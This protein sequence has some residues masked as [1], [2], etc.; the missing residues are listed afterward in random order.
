MGDEARNILIID[1][2]PD[3]RRLLEQ[4]LA[5]EGYNILTASTGAEAEQIYL[6]NPPDLVITDIIMPDR[7]G[8]ETIRE[9]R[10][11]YP[12]MTIV[13][14]SGGGRIDSQDYLVLAR[15]LGADRTFGKPF[16][17]AEMLNYIRE[18]LGDA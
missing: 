6:E 11:M 10:R 9:M 13:A 18:A 1:D 14:I 16:D 7:E 4:F 3:I 17:L 8:I 5:R 2:D 15:K 12:E